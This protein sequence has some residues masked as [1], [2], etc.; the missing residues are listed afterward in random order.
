M[1]GAVKE[2]DGGVA[3]DVVDS[4]IDVTCPGES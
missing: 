2:D 1:E 4:V 3:E